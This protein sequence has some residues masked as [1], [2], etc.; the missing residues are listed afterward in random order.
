MAA[1][2]GVDLGVSGA[3]AAV[4]G[5]GKAVVADLPIIATD[6]GKRVDGRELARLLRSLCDAASAPATIVH[7][8]IRV[9]AMPGRPISHSREGLL[10]RTRGA[11]EAI[12][13]VLGWRIVVVQPSVWKR[14]Y[15]LIRGEKGDSLAMAVKLYPALG[16]D[17]ARVKDHNRAEALLIAHYAARSQLEEF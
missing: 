11:L 3:V 16:G 1:V 6:G 12:A 13:D 15:G 7:E 8:D 4:H 2:I 14:H 9:R 5:P 17:L 10:M